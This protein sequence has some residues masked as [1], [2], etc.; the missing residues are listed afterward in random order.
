[1]GPRLRPPSTDEFPHKLP[2]GYLQMDYWLTIHQYLNNQIQ[3]D[4]FQV[5]KRFLRNFINSQIYNIYYICNRRRNRSELLHI[6]N[7][8]VSNAPNSLYCHPSNFKHHQTSKETLWK[9]WP[10]NSKNIWQI[11]QSTMKAQ[12]KLIVNNHIRSR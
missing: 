5:F 11:P 7:I 6:P 10:K 1:M 12:T 4:H 2:L 8:I 9:S 3:F